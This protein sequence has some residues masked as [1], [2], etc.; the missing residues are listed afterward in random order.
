MCGVNFIGFGSFAFEFWWSRPG[1]CTASEGKV[2]QLRH[3]LQSREDTCNY[4]TLEG[5][6][7]HFVLFSIIV[8]Q[9]V[10][11]VLNGT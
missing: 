4:V 7:P 9:G 8:C 11:T 5:G 10:N 1:I 6:V 3:V 2:A